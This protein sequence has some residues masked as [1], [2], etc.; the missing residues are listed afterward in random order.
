MHLQLFYFERRVQIPLYRHGWLCLFGVVVWDPGTKCIE[1]G[2]R[3]S[4]RNVSWIS[5]YRNNPP[6]GR[7]NVCY[8]LQFRNRHDRQKYF[9][10]IIAG[11]LIFCAEKTVWNIIVLFVSGTY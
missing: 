2:L 8:I 11:R 9:C 4:A 10:S 1:I 5:R 6:S 7:N 3:A